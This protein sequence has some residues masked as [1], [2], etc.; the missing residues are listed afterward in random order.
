MNFSKGILCLESTIKKMG[1]EIDRDFVFEG[2]HSI[3]YAKS[4][5]RYRLFHFTDRSNLKSIVSCGGLLSWKQIEE[6][7]LASVRF[8]SN[9]TSRLLDAQLGLQDYVRLSWT[10]EHPM[11]YIAKK[12]KRIQEAVVLDVDLK[13]LSKPGILFADKNANRSGAQFGKGL[14]MLKKMDL[15]FFNRVDRYN[16]EEN[17]DQFQQEILV[18]KKIPLKFLSIDGKNLV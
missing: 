7:K 11:K 14:D 12:E 9:I 13:I 5:N 6:R 16:A 2:S 3:D 4:Y 15:E 1:K 10:K 17:R 8:G 18:P